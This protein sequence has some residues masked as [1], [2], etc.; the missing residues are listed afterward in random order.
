MIHRHLAELHEFYG[1]FMG[2]RIARKHMGWYLQHLPVAGDWRKQ[3][4]ALGS[5]TEQ[6]RLTDQIYNSLN[7]KELA[8]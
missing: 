6:R 1:D 4:N 2:V 5:P 7:N 3:F 8:A